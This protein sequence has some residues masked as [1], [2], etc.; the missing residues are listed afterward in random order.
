MYSLNSIEKFF[1]NILN[2]INV[3][4][5]KRKNNENL[6]SDVI[7]KLSYVPV[8]YTNCAID[9]Q[10]CYYD[11][12]KYRDI[13]I[14]L[15]NN[16]KPVGIWPISIDN[17]FNF[18]SLGRNLMEPLF[19]KN[20]PLSTKQT[21]LKKI[22]KSLLYLKQHRKKLNIF[23]E[24]NFLNENHTFLSNPESTLIKNCSKLSNEYI[25]YF[26][27][28]INKDSIKSYLRKSFKSLVDKE[29]SKFKYYILSNEDK[30]TW[31]NFRNLHKKVAGK[32][33]RPI[34]TWNNQFDAIKNNNGFLVYALDYNTM[35]GGG[36][37]QFS[38]DEAIYG[39]GAYIEDYKKFSIG[40]IIQYE[41]IKYMV[42]KNIKWYKLGNLYTSHDLID[43][44]SK[45]ISYFLSGFSSHIYRKNVYEL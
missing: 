5:I 10:I 22:I 41:A 12:K 8:N 28:N 9:Y 19:C 14:I 40:H 18:S 25:S 43:L 38:K 32:I 39:T 45:N 24:K 3:N 42:E 21:I 27:L 7:F 1:E 6:W 31:K 26:D 37:F 44:K 30:N 16:K 11:E 33:T 13:S 29:K 4:F 36:F 15:T 34:S 2:D 23:F 35:I 17:K 20:L